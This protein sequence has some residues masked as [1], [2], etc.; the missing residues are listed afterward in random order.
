MFNL[1]SLAL[2]SFFA[3]FYL[4]S[5]VILAN[6]KAQIEK[7]NKSETKLDYDNKSNK[8]NKATQLDTNDDLDKSVNETINS[9]LEK[10]EPGT[11]GVNVTEFKTDN[12]FPTDAK[13][14]EKKYEDPY[15]PYNRTM[16]D[17]NKQIDKYILK[18]LSQI[19]AFITPLP[20]KRMVT[21]FFNNIYDLNVFINDAL[22]GHMG[23]AGTSLS[24]LSL[25]STF[26]IFG[27][28]DVATDV[29]YPEHS[30]DYGVTF[31]RMGMTPSAYFVIPLMGPSTIRDA[32]GRAISVVSSPIY[33][34]PDEYANPLFALY[35]VDNRA[36][37]LTAEKIMDTVADDEY[38]FVRNSYLDYRD[39]LISGEKVDEARENNE[40]KLIDDIFSSQG[41]SDDKP[42][43]QTSSHVSS[44]QSQTND[45]S[46]TLSTEKNEE[47]TE[48]KN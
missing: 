23:D 46:S 9:K 37:L 26:G 39:S 24:R 2:V 36:N 6:S 21:N 29:G 48:N 13:L 18:P 1:K 12:N 17:I 38:V 14:E 20:A 42:A 44:D 45:S 30:N 33:F 41:K 31:G 10:Q 4:S 7:Q 35:Y 28:I 47:N 3:T 40:E 43:D 25:N 27:L 8:S 34:M 19:Y 11:K 16:Y 32:A 15:E 5:P 22:Q